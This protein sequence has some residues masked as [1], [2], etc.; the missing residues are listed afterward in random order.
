MSK[1]YNTGTVA[2]SN[3][4]KL[5]PLEKGSDPYCR[6]RISMDNNNYMDVV[7][8]P[9]VH[10]VRIDEDSLVYD[11]KLDVLLETLEIFATE[12]DYKV[13]QMDGL[14][15]PETVDALKDYGFDTVY[16]VTGGK[17]SCN[18]LMLPRRK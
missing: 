6:S 12:N 2:F 10:F 3:G 13:I 1:D 14:I 11:N 9:G 18:S 4:C 7:F 5:I 8:S 17:C 15:E 16:T